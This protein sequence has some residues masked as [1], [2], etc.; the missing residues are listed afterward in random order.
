MTGATTEVRAASTPP[1][2]VD[3][4]RSPRRRVPRPPG[5]VVLAGLLGLVTMVALH[6]ALVEDTYITLGY[7][8]GLF[9]RGEWGLLPGVPSNTMTSP[10]NA[11]LLSGLSILTR[12]P[13]SSLWVVAVVNP[14][15]CA[16]GLLRLGRSWGVGTRLAWLGVPLLFTDPFLM[17][18]ICMET[19]PA[20]TVLVWLLV[21][22]R[23]GSAVRYGVLS[24]VAV[25]LRPDLVVPVA[26]V[27]LL[28]PAVRRP[29]VRSTLVTTAVAGVV[30]LPWFLWSWVHLGSAIP[31]TL[32]IKSGSS[33]A[34]AAPFWNGLWAR[35][36]RSYPD[37]VRPALWAL[38][39]GL[40]AVLAAPLLGR[41][42]GVPWRAPLTVA[43]AGLAYYLAFIA[44]DVPPFFWY[45][46]LTVAA[47]TL[48]LA[49]ALAVLVGPRTAPRRR[50]G[51]ALAVVVAVV[52]ASPS[53]YFWGRSVAQQGP[54]LA[55]GPVIGNQATTPQYRALG[56]DLARMPPVAIHSA[57]EFG[58]ILYYCRCTLVDRFDDRARL[59]RA[60]ERQRA[61]SQLMA[62]NYHFYRPEDHHPIPTRW[63]LHRL[64]QDPGPTVR[65]WKVGT[66]IRGTGWMALFHRGVPVSPQ[67]WDR[68]TAR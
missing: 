37:G 10:L 48:T 32:A 38:G 54:V 41:W 39:A 55:R 15:L 42:R 52:V 6:D 3:P 53:A 21:H 46:G 11:L 30:C 58:E 4:P 12:D 65:T 60:L 43:A 20:V 5:P 66:P 25:L 62:L 28:T 19:L 29:L 26:V 22:A 40:V 50:V 64:R 27:W 56:R 2:E 13:L 63:G 47:A 67:E 57:G 44:I 33:F 59:A 34:R 23:E 31:D 16:W 8:R 14:V 35:F 18:T 17:G 45:Y 36:G 1:G 68:L 7:A 49:W 51:V 24:G 9:E 61:S